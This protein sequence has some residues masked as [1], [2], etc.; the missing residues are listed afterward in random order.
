VSVVLG[1]IL[2]GSPAASADTWTETSEGDFLG[3][4]LTDANATPS[5]DVVLAGSAGPTAVKQGMVLDVGPSA[6]D[7]VSAYN[8]SVLRE[9]DGSCKMWYTAYDGSRFRLAFA[10]SPDGI[11][12][13]KRGVAIDV[14]TAPWNFD[15]VTFASVIKEGATYHMWFA[16]G[17]WTG[18][19]EG[20]WSQAY[21]ASSADA[22][23]WSISGPVLGLGSLNSWDDSAVAG[24]WVVYDGS[25]YRMYYVGWDG[26]TNRIGLATSATKTGFTKYSGN[27]VLDRGLPGSWDDVA[28]GA[29][30]V[31]IGSPWTM[32]YGGSD[33]TTM[34]LG[35][36]FSSDGYVWTK[37]SGNPWMLPGP[38]AWDSDGIAGG[39]P[40][41]DPAGD[42]LYYSG[43]DGAHW[44]IGTPLLPPGTG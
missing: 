2:L 7:S 12:W 14:L 3:G 41:S 37:Y 5:G 13:T 15:S 22:A 6:Y 36:A 4:T 35:L 40:V 31:M 43:G 33:G 29:G 28:L 1:G 21:Y 20:F 17:Y 18:G 44:R 32:Y 25:L 19:P 24:P 10:D 16:A 30:S 39:A 9:S 27:P 34:R 42:R 8:P 11:V 38:A 23:S 26:N